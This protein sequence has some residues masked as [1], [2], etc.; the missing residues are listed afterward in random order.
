M[1]FKRWYAQQLQHARSSH[2]LFNHTSDQWSNW[3]IHQSIQ[4]INKSIN[5]YINQSSNTSI[6]HPV[7][8]TINQSINTSINHPIYQLIHKSSN[9]SIIAHTCLDLHHCG[10]G[11]RCH[12]RTSTRCGCNRWP[13][14]IGTPVMHIA[15]PR[16]P[17]NCCTQSRL[18]RRHSRRHHRSATEAEHSVHSNSGTPALCTVEAL[19]EKGTQQWA[20][21]TQQWETGTQQW[22]TGSRP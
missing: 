3:S 8:Q 5:Q 16:S 10:H 7:R 2:H 4:Y 19:Q 12:H 1:I 9:T 18:I 11:S 22:E 20:T 15:D 21:G 6:D 13:S 17:L 14:H